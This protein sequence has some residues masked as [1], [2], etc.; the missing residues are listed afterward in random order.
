[1]I[2]TEARKPAVRKPFGKRKQEICVRTMAHTKAIGSLSY[3]GF[4][5]VRLSI[6]LVKILGKTKS[7]DYT[8][9]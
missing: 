4:T 8:E 6:V 2:R 5:K 7:E 3:G 1:M 9:L